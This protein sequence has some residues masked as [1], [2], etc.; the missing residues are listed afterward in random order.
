MLLITVV[1]CHYLQV[2]G[3]AWNGAGRISVDPLCSPVSLLFV[4]RDPVGGVEKT[5]HVFAAI[6]AALQK[7]EEHYQTSEEERIKCSKGPYFRDCNLGKLTY[8]NNTLVQ[9]NKWLYEATAD[10]GEHVVVKFVRYRYGEDVHRYLNEKG[11][12]PKLHQVVTLPGN[13]RAVIMEK[14]GGKQFAEEDLE[15][16]RPKLLEL[17]AALK[18]RKFVHGDLRPQNITVSSDK[19]RVTVV[20][21]D[22]AGVSGSA[23]YPKE[24][25]LSPEC[26]WH[27]DV[28]CGGVIDH[29]HDDHQLKLLGL[30][31]ADFES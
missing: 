31:L 29:K 13:W 12:A 24:I 23:T 10:G 30:K 17:R 26:K 6:D 11:L 21:F 4:S 5:A 27:E 9:E 18:E 15:V 16:V 22:W 28:E 3:A 19:K 20:D 2:F 7:L 14:V 25:N 1:G 8:V